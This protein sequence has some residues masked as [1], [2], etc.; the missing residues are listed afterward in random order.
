[1]R[2]LFRF[3]SVLEI[4][5]DDESVKKKNKIKEDYLSTL[6]TKLPLIWS[7]TSL[8]T[9]KSRCFYFINSSSNTY[10]QNKGR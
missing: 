6:Y 8:G 3:C 5:F 9:N 7:Y 1:M 2:N 4:V 10:V